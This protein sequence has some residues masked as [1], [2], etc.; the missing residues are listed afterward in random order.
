MATLQ[1][2]RQT[3]DDFLA[4]L[5]VNKIVPKEELYF[6]RH[7]RY[8]GA[9]VSPIAPV[10]DGG[11]GMFALRPAH[12]EQFIA[13]FEFSIETPIP[14]Q[15]EI[16][17]HQRGDEHGFTAMVHVLYNG[18]LYRREKTYGPIG[19]GDSPWHEVTRL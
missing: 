16:H 2:V 11:T 14:M 9:L 18:K 15:I 17:P 1:E 5:W 6:S 7:G 10:E 13:D 4:D 3:V 19:Y 12:Y 8:A